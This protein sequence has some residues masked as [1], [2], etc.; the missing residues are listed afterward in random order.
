M[1]S[2]L[3]IELSS[4]SIQKQS[5]YLDPKVSNNVPFLTVLYKRKK[6]KLQQSCLC[7]KELVLRG[8]VLGVRNEELMTSNDWLSLWTTLRKQCP[9]HVCSKPSPEVKGVGGK[10]LLNTGVCIRWKNRQAGWRPTPECGPCLRNFICSLRNVFSLFWGFFLC[11]HH[12]D[13][14]LS[15]APSPSTPH[16]LQAPYWILKKQQWDVQAFSSALLSRTAHKSSWLQLSLSPE[17][18]CPLT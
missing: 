3:K 10:F 1:N 6:K 9:Q 7:F 5:V 14:V 2:Q 4:I 17:K 16:P 15:T 13:G 11:G 12:Q 8:L 18:P